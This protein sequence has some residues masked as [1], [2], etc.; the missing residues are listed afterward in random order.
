MARPLATITAELEALMINETINPQPDFQA[1]QAILL[2]EAREARKE[3]P[4]IEAAL[5]INQAQQLAIVD[6]AEKF[7][8]QNM[9]RRGFQNR[10]TVGDMME[11]REG[12]SALGEIRAEILRGN[13]TPEDST[14]RRWGLRRRSY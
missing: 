1:K 4:R 11:N 10:R 7:I 12:L 2:A 8:T 14:I 3:D 6:A 5:M 13:L 9:T